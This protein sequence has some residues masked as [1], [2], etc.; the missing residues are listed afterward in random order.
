MDK[1]L[2]AFVVGTRP[3]AIKSATVILELKSHLDRCDVLVIS[4]GQHREMLAQ[5]LGAFGIEP[6]ID[7][8][9]MK[10]GQ[11]LAEVTSAAVLGLERVF[12]ERSPQF[13]FAQGDTTTTFIASLVAFYEHIPFGH[14]E[15]GLRT[16]YIDNPFPEEFN[17]RVTGLIATQ[18]YAPTAWARDNLLNEGKHPAS[19]FVTGNTGIDAVLRVAQ[20]TADE[21]FPEYPG[22]V[23]LLTTHRREN[24]GEPQAAV[25]RAVKR[26]AQRHPDTLWVVSMHRNP[27]VRET[28]TSVLGGCDRVRLIEPPDYAPFVKLIK[29]SFL[30]LTDSGGVQEEAPAFGVPVLVLRETTERPEGVE[31]GSAKLVGT[32]EQRVF[33]EGCLLLESPEAYQRMS[34][35]V[36]PYGDGKAAARTRWAALKYLGIESDEVPM[37][38]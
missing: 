25:A 32:D 8:G 13:V 14:I 7:L 18:H 28:L 36:S 38:H 35:A 11:T 34:R 16:P 20:T 4:T 31:A 3:D 30:I 21:W 22:R 26:L 29:R 24:W 2:L 1:P 27:K 10:H 17:R 9:I 37:W 33:E 5:A 12:K 19:V 15:A 23:C 6:D